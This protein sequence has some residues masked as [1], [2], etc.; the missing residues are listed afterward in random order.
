MRPP[1]PH[2]RPEY[3]KAAIEAGFFMPGIWRKGYPKV[4]EITELRANAEALFGVREQSAGMPVVNH[5]AM[6]DLANEKRKLGP[7]AR[8]HRLAGEKRAVA[9]FDHYLLN[10]NDRLDRNAR[11]TSPKRTGCEA[12]SR[13]EPTSLDGEG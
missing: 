2:Q 1:N 8:M 4:D 13:R 3:T 9:L 6:A 11:Q 10:G 5:K 12:T 7:L